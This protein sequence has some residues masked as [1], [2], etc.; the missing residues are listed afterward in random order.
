MPV[1]R[2]LLV[3]LRLREARPFQ[4]IQHGHG[5]VAVPPAGFPRSLQVLAPLLRMLLQILGGMPAHER[6]LQRP[7]GLPDDRRPDELLLQEK[8]NERGPAVKRALN[9]ED[10]DPRQMIADEEVMTVW[11]HV[12]ANAQDFPFRRQHPIE[13]AVVPS[14]LR[15]D[16]TLLSDRASAFSELRDDNHQHRPRVPRNAEFSA[17]R[18]MVMAP[19][20]IARTWSAAERGRAR[21]PC[22][23]R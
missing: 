8:A 3:V 11:S 15:P 12:I 21:R 13:D 16:R 10:V 18:R 14:A 20:I 19:R 23:G 9:G 7:A 5:K 2:L 6:K 4:K 1:R 22:C 17:T